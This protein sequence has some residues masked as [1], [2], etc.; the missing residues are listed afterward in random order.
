M[1][2]DTVND[3]QEVIDALKNKHYDLILMDIQMPNMNGLEA[4]AIIRNELKNTIPIIALTV[5]V[6]PSR[7]KDCMSAGMDDFVMKPFELNELL[8]KI[9]RLLKLTVSST[10]KIIDYS[11]SKKTSLIDLHRVL[12]FSSSNKSIK[13]SLLILLEEIPENL[14]M[15]MKAISEQDTKTTIESA[16]RLLNL[17]FYVSVNEF[18]DLIRTIEEKNN[19]DEQTDLVSIHRIQELWKLIE[20]E[21]KVVLVSLG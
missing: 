10:E 5:S 14:S 13:E 2:I 1:K 20:E 9:A 15:M 3:G 7:I 11:A 16:H 21:L 8:S 18:T 4:T 19:L 17:S 6:L 12:N